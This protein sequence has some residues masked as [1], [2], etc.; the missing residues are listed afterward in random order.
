M[1]G[2]LE[3]PLA[4]TS[5]RVAVIL[6][7]SQRILKDRHHQLLDR[8]DVAIVLAAVVELLRREYVGHEQVTYC[9]IF[10]FHFRSVPPMGASPCFVQRAPLASF[11]KLVS[12]SAPMKSN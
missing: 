7:A 8:T 2:L 4:R 5:L 3:Q 12:D 9:G 6:E 1:L 10:P 11:A